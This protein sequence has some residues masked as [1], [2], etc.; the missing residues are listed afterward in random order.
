MHHIFPRQHA[1]LL[2]QIALE[3]D[4]PT[5]VYFESI[6]NEQINGLLDLFPDLPVRWLYAIKANDNPH[7]M[8]RILARGFGFNT[9]S[10][11]EVRLAER[12]QQD[13]RRI[14]YTENNMTDLE[15]NQAIDSDVVLNVGSLSRLKKFCAHPKASGCCIRIKPDIG[16]GHHEHVDT[17]HSE[18]KFG[19]QIDMLPEARRVAKAAGVEIFGIHMHIGSGINEPKNLLGAMK[20][21]LHISKDFPDLTMINF[22]GGIPI[23]YKREEKDF[24]LPELKRLVTPLLAEDLSSRPKSFSYWFEPGRW[25]VGSCGLLLTRVTTM[26]QQGQTQYIG[27]DTGFNHLIR[28][29]MYD[30][31]HEVENISAESEERHIYT[32]SGNIC[33]S[34]DILAKNRKIRHTQEDDLLAI[35]DAGAYGMTMASH[36]NRRRLP[37]EILVDEH[38]GI[39]QIRKRKSV[40]ESLTAFLDECLFTE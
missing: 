22:G 10:F 5:Y 20:K 12:L 40:D 19:I 2:K 17:G 13:H 14:F 18:S 35:L 28:P 23:P 24:N 26:K 1:A 34:G 11:E 21:L 6:L 32:V 30:S 15:M 36:Y 38:G 8:Q 39:Q 27:T 29:A 4:T 7:L 25:I 16:D 9:V 31:W 33:E 3:Y 37:A